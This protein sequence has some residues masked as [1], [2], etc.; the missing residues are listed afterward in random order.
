M[1]LP[2]PVPSAPDSQMNCGSAREIFRPRSSIHSRTD[3][4]L[5]EIAADKHRSASRSSRCRC[6][7]RCKQFRRHLSRQGDLFGEI[8]VCQVNT[9]GRP[10][11]NRWSC[12]SHVYQLPHGPA[13][14]SCQ[15]D[16]PVRHRMRRITFV[17]IVSVCRAGFRRVERQFAIFAK[18]KIARPCLPRRPDIERCPRIAAGLK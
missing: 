11:T 6:R 14:K 17:R 13:D 4:T 3:S 5:A 9:S 1:A 2:L 8:L 10:S 7:A 16:D 12:T 18:I 15:R